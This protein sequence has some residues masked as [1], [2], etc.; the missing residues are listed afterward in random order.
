[1]PDVTTRAAFKQ[2]RHSL[3]VTELKQFEGR[4]HSLIV[5]G[6]WRD[7]ALACLAWLNGQKL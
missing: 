2:Y 3:A 1:M 4:S 7:V 5:D 6:G